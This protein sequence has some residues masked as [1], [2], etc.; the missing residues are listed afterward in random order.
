[1]EN[2][3]KET[4]QNPT[5]RPKIYT[6][7]LRLD[8]YEDVHEPTNAF[9]E[10]TSRFAIDTLSITDNKDA[11]NSALKLNFEKLLDFFNAEI[12]GNKGESE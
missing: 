5:G 10:P 2:Y 7:R 12:Y 6:Y 9:K 1:M 4:S 3:S 11:V 8:V